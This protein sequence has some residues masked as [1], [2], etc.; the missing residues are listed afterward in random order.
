MELYP[1][2]TC[3]KAGSTETYTC[4]TSDF[5]DNPDVTAVVNLYMRRGIGTLIGPFTIG[6]SSWKFKAL[7]LD[8]TCVKSEQIGFIGS[9]YFVGIMVS[10]LT[11]PRLSDLYG[12][13][14]PILATSLVQLPMYFWCFWILLLLFA[15]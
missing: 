6:W 12:R 9:V 14:W 10:V 3:T 4:E 5:C 1:E 8:L 7:F 13:K 2:Y 15:T 11:L